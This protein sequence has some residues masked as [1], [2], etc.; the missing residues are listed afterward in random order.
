MVAFVGLDLAWTAH[1]PSGLCIVEMAERSAVV[2]LSC[3]VMSTEELASR[4]DGLGRDVVAAIDAP[5][6]IEPG[7]TAERILAS[8]FGRYRA[9]AHAANRSLLEQHPRRM[10]GP[11][12][13]ERLAV[14]GWEFDPLA[15][16]PRARGRYA[17]EVYPHAFHVTLFALAERLP[18]KRKR[19]RSTAFIRDHLRGYQLFLQDALEQLWPCVAGAPAV[20]EL[21]AADACLA[22]GTALKDFED[23]L[24][25]LSCALAAWLAW[26]W[27][28]TD[29]DVLGHW[30]DGAVVVPGLRFD[31]RFRLAQS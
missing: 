16:V 30:R 20:T 19:R 7:R 17:L 25:A 18:Y 12:L 1:R 23:R 27:G 5:L 24:D 9:S 28:L 22:R 14:D 6:M 8:R 4:L 2:D 29:A 3:G 15:I 31:P 10:A 11:D 21:L 13:A 26:S